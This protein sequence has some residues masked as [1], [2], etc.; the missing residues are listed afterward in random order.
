M[1][2]SL[3]LVYYGLLPYSTF[4]LAVDRLPLAFL[5]DFLSIRFLAVIMSFSTLESN[6]M[7]PLAQA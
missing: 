7:L 2:H 4:V 5:D 1:E 3:T 6:G